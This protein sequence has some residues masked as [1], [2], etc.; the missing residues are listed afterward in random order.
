MKKKKSH[1]TSTT[2]GFTDPA[3]KK[4][5]LAGTFNGWSPDSVECKSIGSGR[6]EAVIKL[7]PGRHEYLFV[8]DGQWLSDPHAGDYCPNPYNGVNSVIVVAG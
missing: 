2:F 4:V 7:P 5:C 8:V 6:W 3:A 1:G